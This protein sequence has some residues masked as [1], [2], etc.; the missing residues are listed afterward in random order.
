MDFEVLRA[1]NGVAGHWIWLDRAI[2]WI[3]TYLPLVMGLILAMAWFWPATGAIRA[4]RQRLVVYSVSSALLA[5]GIAQII[6]HLWFRDRPYVHH[7]V[8]LLLPLSPD[9]SFPSDHAAG[10]FGLA[11]PFLLARRRLGWSL[12]GLAVLLAVARVAAGTHYPSD[13]IGGAVLGSATGVLAWNCRVLVERPIA[14]GLAFAGRL[15]L[16]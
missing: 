16:A 14:L 4:D 12:F 9:P 13:V 6:G 5:L 7:P 8:H 11:M 2:R 10:A 3:A 1:F 15:R